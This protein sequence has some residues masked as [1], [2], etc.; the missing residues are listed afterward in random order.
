MGI[1]D[2]ES[3]DKDLIREN[4]LYFMEMRDNYGVQMTG[5]EIRFNSSTPH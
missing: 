2:P 1:A 4:M 5:S 3:A